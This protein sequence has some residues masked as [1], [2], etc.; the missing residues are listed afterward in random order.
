MSA[1]PLSLIWRIRVNAV[2]QGGGME[3]GAGGQLAQRQQDRRRY[4]DD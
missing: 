4:D 2:P 1:N 3:R